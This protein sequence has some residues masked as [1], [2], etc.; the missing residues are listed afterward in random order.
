[1]NKIM[2][3]FDINKESEIQECSEFL[4]RKEAAQCIQFKDAYFALSDIRDLFRR[5]GDF[6]RNYNGIEVSDLFDKL[7]NE[8]LSIIENYNLELD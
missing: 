3:E 1:M 4:I 2:I 6:W 5:K 7:G 8:F